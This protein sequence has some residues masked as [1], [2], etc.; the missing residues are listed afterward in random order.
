MFK[1]KYQSV[2]KPQLT[3]NQALVNK[4]MIDVFFSVSDTGILGKR[5][6]L[7]LPT[8]IKPMTFLLLAQMLYH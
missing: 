2:G 8:V 1:D 6:I 5:K 3:V 7:V 4:I